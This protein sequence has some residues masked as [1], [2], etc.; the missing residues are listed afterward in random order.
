M[1]SRIVSQSGSPEVREGALATL[2][3]GTLALLLVDALDAQLVVLAVPPTLP[4][5]L[6]LL[7]PP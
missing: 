2:T 3:A 5:T 1:E 6:L 4:P 7:Q